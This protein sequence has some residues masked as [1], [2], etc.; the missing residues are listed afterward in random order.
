VK[1]EIKVEEKVETPAKNEVE[2]EIKHKMD[3]IDYFLSMR[4]EESESSED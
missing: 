4:Q 2:D 3:R 1:P